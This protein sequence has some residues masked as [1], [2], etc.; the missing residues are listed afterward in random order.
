MLI[1]VFGK[2]MYFRW[3]NLTAWR[4]PK[5]LG[6]IPVKLIWLWW[7]IPLAFLPVFPVLLDQ[8]PYLVYIPVGMYV[9]YKVVKISW[10]HGFR[11]LQYLL[12]CL[13]CSK[14]EKDVTVVF[15]DDAQPLMR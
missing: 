7:L 8:A 5:A 6:G 1:K 3:L 13:K 11:N 14:G 15:I 9:T 12:D 4:Y 10:K 2:S